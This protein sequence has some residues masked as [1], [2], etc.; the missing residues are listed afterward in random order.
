[1][2]KLHWQEL[3]EMV[4]VTMMSTSLLP[5]HSRLMDTDLISEHDEDDDGRGEEGIACQDVGHTQPAPV[6]E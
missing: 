2:A 3:V 1:M 6:I 4:M 5:S